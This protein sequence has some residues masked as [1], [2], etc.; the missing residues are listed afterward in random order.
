MRNTRRPGAPDAEEHRRIGRDGGWEGRNR[1]VCCAGLDVGIQSDAA[2]AA[3]RSM[4]FLRRLEL[5]LEVS[6]VLGTAARKRRAGVESKVAF[7][8]GGGQCNPGCDHKSF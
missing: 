4:K 6:L 7:L 2:E 1:S 3:G 5:L 8:L